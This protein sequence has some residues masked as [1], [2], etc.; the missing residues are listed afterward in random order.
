MKILNRL[1]HFDERGAKLSNE[2]IGGIITFI[3]M[4]YILPVNASILSSPAMGM[5]SAGVFAMT[6]I[7]SCIV[8]L[9]MGLV[10]NYP[11]ALSAGMGLN[12]YLAFTLSSNLGFTSWQQKMIIVTI[13]GII[14][15]FFSL[16]PVRKIIIESIPKDLKNIISAALGV[17]IAFVGLKGSGIIV[18]DESTLV[19]LGSF[20]DPEIGRASCRERV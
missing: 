15:F 13:S 7:V 17:F 10:A 11:I 9:I 2:I 8:T 19:S 3:A 4:C 18:S 6:A 12:A 20:L 5:D 1:F 16:T 14:F